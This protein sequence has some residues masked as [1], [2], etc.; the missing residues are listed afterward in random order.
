VLNQ[1]QFFTMQFVFLRPLTTIAVII[2]D[3]YHESRWD[4]SYPQI[5]INIV[6]NISIF[7]AF[8]GLLR[9]YH[10]VKEDLNWCHPFSKFMAIKGVVFI[11]F[12]QSVVISII[13]HAVYKGR[14]DVNGS[15][16][17]TEWSKQAQSFLICFEMF[18]FAIVHCQVFPTEEWEPGFREKQ[19]RRIKATFGDSLAIKDFVADVKTVIRSRRKGNIKKTNTNK[20][21]VCDD[22]D[23]DDDHRASIDEL[24]TSLVRDNVNQGAFE[25]GDLSEHSAEDGWNRIEEFIDEIEEVGTVAHDADADDEI[26]PN[27]T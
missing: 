19:K 5:Y 2:A 18:A 24:S 22:N 6:T 4:P 3:E 7:F 13:A 27:I 10:V 26:L 15:R 23:N 17:A 8:M 20:K 16:D 21:L 25:I 14:D 1:S 11:T 9:F 12:W